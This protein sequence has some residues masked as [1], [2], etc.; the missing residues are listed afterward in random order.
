MGVPAAMASISIPPA[1][2]SVAR[3]APPAPTLAPAPEKPGYDPVLA[4]EVSALQRVLAAGGSVL[5]AAVNSTSKTNP[6]M[7]TGYE[8]TEIIDSQLTADSRDH[9]ATVVERLPEDDPD[10]FPLLSPTQYG[11]L[12]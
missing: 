9:Q 4:D 7:L 11:D 12:R 10:P 8:S 6:V 3:P 2:P 1:P 5:N